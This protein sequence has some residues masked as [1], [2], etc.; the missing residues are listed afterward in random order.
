[1][2]I[3]IITTVNHNIG[4]DFVREGILFLL[5]Q[6]LGKFNH[7]LIHKHIPITV[8]PE[9]EWFYSSGLSV[10]LDRLP[11]GRGLFWSKIID[12]LPIVPKTDKIL[13]CDLLVQSGAP[14]YWS[15]ANISEWF[16]P[17]IRKR[18]L[19]IADRVPFINIG[20]GTCQ[21]YDS[22]G[23]ELISNPPLAAFIRV[24][25]KLCKVTTLRDQLSKKVL[26]GLGL[27]APVIPC[28]SIFGRDHL[29]ISPQP[30]EY[31]AMNFMGVGGHYEFG[32][33]ID[34]LHWRKTFIDFVGALR[35][36]VPVLLVC[37]DRKEYAEA[38]RILPNVPRFIATTAR[39]YLDCYSRA[40]YFIGCR[41]HGA[42][43]TASFGR[44]AFV[45]G[46][47]SRAR[48]LEEI[49]LESVFVNNTSIESLMA[50]RNDLEQKMA[51][52]PE[53]ML[54][55]KERSFFAYQ[56]AL[57]PLKGLCHP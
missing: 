2:N 49:G 45:I 5:E 23:S 33:Q 10:L 26:N 53:E 6:R 18:Y 56:E 17:L 19:Q 48:M 21:H 39:E 40:R 9:W 41:V 42:F 46:S 11:R 12:T 8:R 7:H 13:T 25:H 16:D 31:V 37:H 14:V 47:D 51:T 54:T 20:A 34:K 52:Y 38:L 44:P 30:P 3:S 50:V 1:M 57:A 28:P 43:A 4:D 29:E 22:D 15:S 32:Q 27:D 55:I 24:L 36:E 35:Q